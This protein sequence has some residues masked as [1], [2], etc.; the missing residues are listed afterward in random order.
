MSRQVPRK[1]YPTDISDE[2]W[3]WI[4]ALLAQREGP[5]RKRTVNIREIVN[6]IF[7]LDKTGCQWDMLPHDFPDYRHVNYYYLEW[8]RSGVWDQV[9]ER[10]RELARVAAGKHPEPS[11]GVLDSQSVKTTN[12]GEER[13]YD[14]GKNIKG[15]KRHILVDTLGLLLLVWVTGATLQ[16][17]DGGVEL[18]D[19]AHEKFPRL[20]KIWADSAYS[21]ELVEYV[22]QWCHFLL[23]IVKRSP[24]QRGFQVQPKRWI[25][26]RSLAWLNPFRRLSK[27]Y[28]NTTQSSE[29]MIKIANIHWMLRRVT[30]A[31]YLY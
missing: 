28:E 16:D 31:L 13:G 19:E 18:C 27:D 21:G 22:A 10:L 15:R 2:A 1:P 8:T 23:E 3:E 14:A 24:Q 17:R 6:A 5:G 12:H 29:A 11:A 25:V 30:S 26:E 4:A 7:Y 20:Q 9:L